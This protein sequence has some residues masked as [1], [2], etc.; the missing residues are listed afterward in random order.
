MFKSGRT[1]ID[2][3]QLCPEN[4]AVMLNPYGGNPH[5]GHNQGRN[6]RHGGGGGAPPSN[7]PFEMMNTH[8]TQMSNMMQQMDGVMGGGMMMDDR[9]G[10]RGG[11]QRGGDPFQS[12]MGP[13]MG[14]M[15]GGMGSMAPMGGM[16]SMMG[17]GG[18][19]SS[20]S[21][22]SCCYSS[23]SSGPGGQ[24]HVVQYSSSSHGAQRPGEEAVAETHR[25]YRDSSGTEKLGVSRRI[26]ERGRSVTAV[27]DA[28]G[29]E[30]RRDNVMNVQ[31]GSTF[32]RE[33]RQNSTATAVNVRANN[34]PVG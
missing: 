5:G 20:Y 11:G 14:P 8:M 2:A 3:R 28:N 24:P 22:S 18:G 4:S 26:G 7:N 32:D 16:G 29:M 10:Q 15:M 27:R 25:E 34:M 21:C 30:E 9:R 31:D 1:R 17:G 19:G 33:W 6:R 12:M 23:S 13:M